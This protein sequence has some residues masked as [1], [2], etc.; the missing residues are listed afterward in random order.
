MKT[1]SHL[2]LLIAGLAAFATPMATAAAEAQPQERRA[3]RE[4]QFETSTGRGGAVNSEVVRTDDG[5]AFS[6]TATDAE[7]NT[8]ATRDTTVTAGDDGVTRTTTVTTPQGDD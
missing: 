1:S 4:R 5:G 6:R 8:I 7:G 2:A 3:T